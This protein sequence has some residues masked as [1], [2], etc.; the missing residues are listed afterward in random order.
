MD[1]LANG[2]RFFFTLQQVSD[3][4]DLTRLKSSHDPRRQEIKE[5]NLSPAPG[6]PQPVDLRACPWSRTTN[7]PYIWYQSHTKAEV[8]LHYLLAKSPS[9][10]LS[11]S[12]SFSFSS[13][14]RRTLRQKWFCL[15]MMM[16]FRCALVLE[17]SLLW[18]KQSSD[19]LSNP[20]TALVLFLHLLNLLRLPWSL[21]STQPINFNNLHSIFNL[22]FIS[23]HLERTVAPHVH[24]AHNIY[25]HLHL[26]SA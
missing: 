26:D 1:I 14:R 13:F 8:A 2:G 9:L 17:S 18:L 22:P 6:S 10:S 20:R 24:L 19:F 23:K 12:C 15:L 21:R 16:H 7:S 3:W 11:F 25:E 5:A 4:E